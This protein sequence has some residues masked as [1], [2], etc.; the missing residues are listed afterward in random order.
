MRDIVDTVIE[1]LNHCV[2]VCARVCACVRVRALTRVCV[3]AFA[4]VCVCACACVRV[5]ARVCAHARVC[6]KPG[7]HS[8]GVAGGIVSSV[9]QPSLHGGVGA[10]WVRRRAWK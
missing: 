4:R 6:A 2:R 7:I 8:S 10:G 1:Y 3:R 9:A 5:C